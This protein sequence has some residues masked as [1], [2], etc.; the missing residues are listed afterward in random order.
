MKREHLLGLMTLVICVVVTAAVV[1]GYVRLF[2]DN[3]MQI[4]LEMFKYARDVK[5]ISPDPLIGHVHGPNRKAHL[6]GVDIATNSK[7]LRDREIPYERTPGTLRVV[8]LGDSVTLGWGVRPEQTYSKL[9]EGMFA[10]KGIKAEV[11]NT[12]VGN[13]KTV[14]EV[15]YFLTEARKYDPD[16]VVVTYSVNDA[17]ILPPHQAPNVFTR[18]CLSCMFI[19]G[20]FD[21]LLRRLS[22]APQWSEYY[23]SLYQGGNG[24]GWLKSKEYFAKLRDYCEQHD[25]GVLIANVP[26]I[27]DVQHYKLQAITDLAHKMADA[28]GFEFVDTLDWMSTVESSKLWLSPGDPHPNLQGHQLIAQ[29]IYSKL[30]PMVQARKKPD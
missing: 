29:A 8:M 28:N 9:L 15:E 11:V 12:G 16:F 23:L 27:H 3:G 4:D 22:A 25:V 17:E 5:V 14:Q 20:R 30:Y 13:F 2:A 24:S 21:T 7:G 10:E 1:E 26:E 6:M 18:N 19:A